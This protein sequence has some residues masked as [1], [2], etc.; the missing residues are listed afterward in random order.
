MSCVLPLVCCCC[1][2]ARTSYHV[3]WFNRLRWQTVQSDHKRVEPGARNPV[4]IMHRVQI[5]GTGLSR[6]V[7]FCRRR[8]VMYTVRLLTVI[9]GVGDC[10]SVVTASADSHIIVILV[11]PMYTVLAKEI[12]PTFCKILIC[13]QKSTSKVLYGHVNPFARNLHVQC[14]SN[15]V[16]DTH[17]STLVL[18]PGS[19]AMRHV[20]AP[21]ILCTWRVEI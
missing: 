11:P 12:Q 1:C 9:V 18:Q 2:D 10:G 13:R 7:K 8:G 15:L 20:N 17:R 6:D 4:S 14:C 16:R 5:M 21:F 3:T 19:S